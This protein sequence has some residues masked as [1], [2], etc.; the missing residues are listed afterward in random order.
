ML[1]KLTKRI[2]LVV[3]VAECLPYQMNL[4]EMLVDIYESD[5]GYLRY[6]GFLKANLVSSVHTFNSNITCMHCS[7]I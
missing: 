4:Q 3:T 1:K 7:D 5:L 6:T 2:T